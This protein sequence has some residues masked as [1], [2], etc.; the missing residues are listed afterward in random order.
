[1]K[2]INIII[3]I[4]LVFIAGCSAFEDLERMQAEGDKISAEIKNVHGIEAHVMPVTEDNLNNVMV[5]VAADEKVK[6]ISP[7]ELAEIIKPVISKHVDGKFEIHLTVSA[8]YKN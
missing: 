4:A 5:M 3:A 6:R 7:N 8:T 1:M 2:Y